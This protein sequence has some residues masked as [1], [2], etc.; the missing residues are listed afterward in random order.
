MI[1]SH[2]GILGFCLAGDRVIQM[3]VLENAVSLG[4]ESIK[5][6]LAPLPAAI[7]SWQQ[8]NLQAFYGLSCYLSPNVTKSITQSQLKSRLDHCKSSSYS[9]EHIGI[10]KAYKHARSL[11]WFFKKIWTNNNQKK[12]QPKP[13]ETL[14]WDL[15]LYSST[16]L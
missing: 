15:V 10:I 8:K 16:S 2:L 3:A 11:S 5:L 14:F 12:N 4:F 7:H 9:L 1:F 6:T 13:T